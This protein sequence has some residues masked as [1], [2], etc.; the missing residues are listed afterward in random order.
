MIAKDNQP[1]LLAD[2]QALFADPPPGDEQTTARSL[3][4][5]HGRVERRRLT[6]SDAPAGHSDWPGLRLVFRLERHTILKA[7][8]EVRGEVV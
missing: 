4:C 6:A 5:G 2:V 8:G 7:T 3:D 1:R